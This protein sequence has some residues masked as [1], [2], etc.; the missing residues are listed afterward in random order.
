MLE[1]D[2]VLKKVP[3]K[4]RRLVKKGRSSPCEEDQAIIV[5]SPS[6]EGESSEESRTEFIE[7]GPVIDERDEESGSA[8]RALEKSS[9]KAKGLAEDVNKTAADKADT[10]AKGA[11][12]PVPVAAV[13]ESIPSCSKPKFKRSLPTGFTAEE[14]RALQGK[15][16]EISIEIPSPR[17]R[18]E[19]LSSVNIGK[20][21]LP[22]LSSRP[23][24]SV[25]QSISVSKGVN[26]ALLGKEGRISRELKMPV[27]DAEGASPSDAGEAMLPSKLPPAPPASEELYFAPRED[28]SQ[29]C[30]RGQ[31]FV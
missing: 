27:L 10:S 21:V 5:H 11:Y 29:V 15:A 7:T 4:R 3:Q 24:R 12:N 6:P 20:R 23:E 8:I 16:A 2:P 13:E 30:F 22:P 25:S 1:R 31:R 19:I 9:D 17:R 14:V 18:R 28:L 26:F